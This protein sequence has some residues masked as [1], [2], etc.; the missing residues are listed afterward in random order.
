MYLLP[1]EIVTLPPAT[2]FNARPD[3]AEIFTPPSMPDRSII[4]PA[5][6]EADTPVLTVTLPPTLFE[7][8]VERVKFPTETMGG[9][10]VQKK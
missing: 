7:L 1:D 5:E 8:P 10:G 4:A 6:N 9:K 2:L 3:A